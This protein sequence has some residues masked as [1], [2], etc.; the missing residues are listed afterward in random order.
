MQFRSSYCICSGDAVSDQ[1][2]SIHRRR[3][4]LTFAGRGR[5]G[6]QS[7]S[8]SF[9]AWLNKSAQLSEGHPV[10]LYSPLD[11]ETLPSCQHDL[12]Q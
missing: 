3:T 11:S 7:A 8:T 12:N 2:F 1:G 10:T 5:P 4:F 9:Q 6:R